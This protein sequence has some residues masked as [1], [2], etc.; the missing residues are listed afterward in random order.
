MSVGN[1]DSARRL[2]GTTG[3]A[4]NYP[5]LGGAGAPL[6]AGWVSVRETQLVAY[7]VPAFDR[8]SEMLMSTRVFDLAGMP[9]RD[10]GH[11][12]VCFDG[13]LLSGPGRVV[14]RIDE[15]LV[16]GLTLGTVEGNGNCGELRLEL[17][18]DEVAGQ[19][20]ATV[21]LVWKA[22]VHVLPGAG[23]REQSRQRKNVLRLLGAMERQVA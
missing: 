15:S 22:R 3:A 7:G 5:R 2:S 14:D 21:A 12:G 1:A 20:D 23:R 13:G 4:L 16:Q 6:P 8:L 17:C 18:F 10:T 19:V 9:I 11:D